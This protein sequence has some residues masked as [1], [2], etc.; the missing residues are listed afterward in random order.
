MGKGS[1]KYAWVLDKLKAERER[2]ITI[3]IA[4]WKF[5]TVKY[6]V[7]VIDAPG[8]RDFIK[9]MIT[10]TSQADCAVLIVAAGV[11]EFEAGISANGQTRE[12][13]LLAYTLGVKQL[14]VGVNKMDSTEPPYSSVSVM[15]VYWLVQVLASADNVTTPACYAIA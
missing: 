10:G 9:N 2:G 5:E 3:D 7:T 6:Y 11:G 14:I 12:H 4:L 13:A 8:H 15:S 1:F